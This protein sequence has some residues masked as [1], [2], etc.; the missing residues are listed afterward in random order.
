MKTKNQKLKSLYPI[1]VSLL[2]V[3]CKA[4][5]PKI[6]VQAEAQ[7]C[8]VIRSIKNRLFFNSFELEH[9]NESRKKLD[10]LLDLTADITLRQKNEPQECIDELKD[11]IW[12][13]L[14]ALNKHCERI[15]KITIW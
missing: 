5:C 7:F 6:V 3:G 15:Y 13:V 1:C 14:E 4:G 11:H 2:Q 9:C 12:D 8:I 10:E